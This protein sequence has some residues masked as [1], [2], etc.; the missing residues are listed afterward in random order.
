MVQAKPQAEAHDN[1]NTEAREAAPP[2]LVSRLNRRLARERRARHD[3]ERLL[4]AKSLELYEANRALSALALSLEK[5]VELR[6]R[7]LSKERLKAL[8]QSE[9]DSLTGIAN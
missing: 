7:E 4:E 9:F 2:D 8:K 1:V 6:T 5:R 3:A